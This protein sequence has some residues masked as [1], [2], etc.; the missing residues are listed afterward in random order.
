MP[1]IPQKVGLAKENFIYCMSLQPQ[2]SLFPRAAFFIFSSSRPHH[3][4]TRDINAC[5]RV[6]IHFSKNLKMKNE[7]FSSFSFFIFAEN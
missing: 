6:P 7:N 2:M 4:K 3:S 5:T 1:T